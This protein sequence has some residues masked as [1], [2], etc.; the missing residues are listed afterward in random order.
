MLGLRRA[1]SRGGAPTQQGDPPTV[2]T[3]AGEATPEVAGTPASGRRA[4]RSRLL[5]ATIAGGVAAALLGGAA[6]AGLL[7]A[8]PKLRLIQDAV[9]LEPGLQTVDK[10]AR[11]LVG[12]GEGVYVSYQSDGL[13][14]TRWNHLVW[15]SVDHGAAVTAGL[16]HLEW[17]GGDTKGGVLRA[18]EVV[19]QKLG[20]LRIDKR[21]YHGTFVRYLGR[22]FAD[23]PDGPDSR[24]LTITVTRR[25]TDGRVLLDVE[26]PG[27]AVVAVHEFRYAGYTYRGL[28]EQLAPAV[29]RDGRW[30]IVTRNPGTGR[31]KIPL[32]WWEDLS[33]GGDIG[34][35]ARGGDLATTSAP[36][37]FYLASTMTGMAL[38]TTAYS[39]VD[40]SHGGRVD[41]SVW[42]PRLQARLY[43]GDDPEYLVAAHSADVGRMRP[44][45]DWATEGAIVGVRG[46]S[47]TI[48][49]AVTSLVDAGARISAVLVRDGG[50]RTRYPDWDELVTKLRGYGVRTMAAASPTVTDP[51]LRR[52]AAAF[53]YLVEHDDG[54]STD[55]VDLTNAQ[56]FRW[57]AGVLAATMRDD[58]L[59]GW[60]A[61]G[62]DD[63]PMDARLAK[64]NASDAHNSWPTRWAQVTRLACQLA[65]RP[66]CLVLQDSAA[67]STPQ[68]AGVFDQGRQVTDWSEQ[69]GLV[70]VLRGKLSAG[71]SGMAMVSSGV[72]GW[73]SP[74]VRFWPDPKRTDELLA[75]WAELEAFGSVLRTEDGDAPSQMPQVWDSPTRRKAFAHATQLFAA[76]ATYRQR[77]MEA[78]A[79]TGL[80]VV[81]PF[82]IEYPDA[83]QSATSDEFFFGD[84]LLVVPVLHPAQRQV[85]AILPAGDWVEL[86][87]GRT[88]SGPTPYP[89]PTPSGAQPDDEKQ[90]DDEDQ[91]LQPPPPPGGGP[92]ETPPPAPITV[93]IP[94]PLGQPVV[95][96]RQ[97]DP[98]GEALRKALLAVPKLGLATEP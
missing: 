3:T 34:G 87:T 39:V 42:A 50:D 29:L 33:P 12:L 78:A 28:G 1:R 46:S 43:D 7:F 45:P 73:S 90:D 77:V 2:E 91:G 21:E 51:A 40:L 25:M 14:I 63:L 35:T 85:D 27:A 9:D 4:R 37:P 54:R 18:R 76:T 41:V 89:T 65:N 79:R 86:F 59:S 88:Y 82:W 48:L 38:D 67:E 55:L 11:G 32:T 96:Y 15:R 75:R 13:R 95:L 66:D 92:D 60:L 17:R 84:S 83:R 10:G 6:G 69:D 97:G 30:P 62:G 61:E 64:G 31:G 16:G 81:R 19:E 80:P 74:D 26:V 20:N 5:R 24:P 23:D 58:G 94:A 22:I 71:L 98:Q 57:Y 93:T 68:Y 53:G 72:G 70:S 47:A 36:M 8:Y 56:A 44:P 49:G 52:R